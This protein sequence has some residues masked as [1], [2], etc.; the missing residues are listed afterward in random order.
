MKLNTYLN[1][2]GNCQEAFRFYEEHLGGKVT[3][4]MTH[5]D[6]PG[7][8]DL[9]ERARSA[10]LH[11]RI[12]IGGVELLGSDVLRDDYGQIRSSYL[13]LTVDSTAE[14]ERIFSVLATGGQTYM[15]MEETFW[16]LRFG[17]CRDPF[18]VLWMI[19]AEKP[20]PVA[21]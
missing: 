15:P 9:P 7:A 19:S 1:F 11:A 10:I 5:A 2:N 13:S 12:T 17:I 18:G 4:M 20:M 21:P 6:A 16:A 14:A 3:M 8:P